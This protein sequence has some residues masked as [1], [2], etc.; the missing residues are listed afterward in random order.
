MNL[1]GDMMMQGMPYAQPQGNFGNMLSQFG[2]GNQ[3]NSIDQYLAYINQL[4]N[5]FGS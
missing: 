4:A 2:Q 1:S 5:P 3:M